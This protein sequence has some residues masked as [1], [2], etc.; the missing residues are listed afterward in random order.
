[1]AFAGC[2][3]LRRYIDRSSRAA[4]KPVIFLAGILSSLDSPVPVACSKVPAIVVA[5]P[6]SL[7]DALPERRMH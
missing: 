6:L 1:M 2:I 3:A 7:G 5:K 4:A